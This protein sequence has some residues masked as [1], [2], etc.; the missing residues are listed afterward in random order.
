MANDIRYCEEARF[1]VRTTVLTVL[2]L[3]GLVLFPVVATAQQA[4]S[5]ITVINGGSSSISC[6]GG[7]ERINVDLNQNVGGDF[8][9]ICFK[10]GLGAPVT[11]LWVT[12]GGTAP[13]PTGEGFVQIPVDLNRGAGGDFIYLWYTK[14]PNCSV[15]SAITVVASGSGSIA[16]PGGFEKI[17]VD[18]NK[19]SGGDFVYLC[20]QM[21]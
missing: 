11:G 21:Q 1:D 16:C 2:M 18:L 15:L 5:E 8:I 7:Y 4:V 19:G 3:I 13:V 9:Y 17:P 10:K 20:E 12:A 14:D 6:P